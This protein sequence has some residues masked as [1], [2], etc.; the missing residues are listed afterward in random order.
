MD[1]NKSITKT[2]LIKKCP[3][4]YHKGAMVVDPGNTFHFYR[5]N[6]DGTWSHKDGGS[7]ITRL[8]NGGNIITDVKNIKSSKYRDFC[9]YYC[10]PKN[11]YKDT[12]MARNDYIKNKLWYKN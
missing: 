7:E 3:P 6:N 8:D 12:R 1:D 5:Q 2:K 9:N 11:K 4:K 10:V